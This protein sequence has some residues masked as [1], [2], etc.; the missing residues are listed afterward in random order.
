VTR[1]T[2]APRAGAGRGRR[3]AGLGGW[4]AVVGV[5]VSV[6][7]LYYAFRGVALGEV[8][9]EIAQADAGLLLLGTASV[10]AVFWI[11]AWR[12]RAILLPIR[13]TSFHGR[14][15]AVSIGFMGNNL[16]P[17]RLGEFM[18]V[19]SL[20]RLERIPV[21]ASAGSLVVERLLDAIFVI[22][23]L[24]LAIV[25]PGFPGLGSPGG[26]AIDFAALALLLGV[27]VA[28]ALLVLFALVLF[29]QRTVAVIERVVERLL[30][31]RAR[32]LIIDSL[33]AF[34]SGL[35][36]LRDPALLARALAW[37][38]VLWLINGFGFWMG[39]RAFG[40][41]LPFAGALFF[42]SCIALGVSVPSAPGFFGTYHAAARVVL[43]GLWALPEVTAVAFAGAFHL[44]GFIP[45]TLIG[46]YFAWR[47]D[48]SFRAAQHSEEIVEEQ[49]EE[50]A[51]IDATHGRPEE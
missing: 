18:R 14:F 7:L 35:G 3:S 12:W 4:K 1:P 10:T 41:D 44:A 50:A 38:A 32:R 40:L 17:A 37:S 8:L 24:F 31:V 15:A 27:A 21:V 43:V 34:L 2:G 36:V 42:Q 23:F 20:S 49:I 19:L 9:R 39:L 25:L 26:G 5:A 48:F 33:I 47:T 11:R 30:P 29:P 28:G 13:E 22:G 6:A 46:L 16:L 51:G 45:I